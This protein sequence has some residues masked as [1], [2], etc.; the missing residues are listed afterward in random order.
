[1][2]RLTNA[3]LK[4]RIDE[5]FYDTEYEKIQRI[6][7]EQEGQKPMEY[8]YDAEQLKKVF[9]SEWKEAYTQL[10]REKK[11]QFW[12]TFVQKIAL[13]EDKSVDAIYFL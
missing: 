1:M 10:S 11:R 9:N 4:G 13:K 2:D 7:H 8:K 5:D 3:Y 6:I 12:K